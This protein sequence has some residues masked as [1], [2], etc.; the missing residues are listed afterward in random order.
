METKY[1]YLNLFDDGINRDNREITSRP[2]MVNCAGCIKTVYTR[3]NFNHKGRQ[4]YYLIYIISGKMQLSSGNTKAEAFDGDVVIFPP[5]KEYGHIHPEN[6]KLNYL[7]VHFTGSD[8]EKILKE[9]KIGIFPQVN[10]TTE[11]NHIQT[12]FQRLFDCFLI[13]DEL[14]EKDLTASLDKLLIE[15]A[16]AIR[17]RD[18][19]R[20]SL[21]KALRYINDYYNTAIKIPDLAKMENMSMTGFNLSFKEKMGASPTKYIINLRMNTARELLEDSDLPIKQISVMCGYP[22][23]HFFAKV[24]KENVGI[25]PKNYRKQHHSDE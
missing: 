8:V 23:Y 18:V 13:N 2:L 1:Y 5:K 4:D 11:K 3:G 12:R 6:E 21:S 24:F 16:R 15:I 22:D 7:W 20:K 19:P 17:D 10:K 14:R 9:Y 25:S